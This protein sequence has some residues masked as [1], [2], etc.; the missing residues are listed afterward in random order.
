MLGPASS[1]VGCQAN[2]TGRLSHFPT[3]ISGRFHASSNEHPLD[4]KIQMGE[5]GGGVEG[6]EKDDGERYRMEERM[7][8]YFESKTKINDPHDLG[9]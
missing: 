2:Q 4:M 6:G 1:G 9:H 5:R 8:T 3:A 7:A